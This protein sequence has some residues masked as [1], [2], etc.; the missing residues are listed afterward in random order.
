MLYGLTHQANKLVEINYTYYYSFLYNNRNKVFFEKWIKMDSD[1]F[2]T[3]IS[4]N[5]KARKQH[6]NKNSKRALQKQ[7]RYDF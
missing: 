7:K 2:A 1:D 6:S 4:N 5:Q 3:V